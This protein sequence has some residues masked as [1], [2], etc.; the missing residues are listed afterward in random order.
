MNPPHRDVQQRPKK[1]IAEYLDGL[2]AQVLSQT[3]VRVIAHENFVSPRYAIWNPDRTR[4]LF[5]ADRDGLREWATSVKDVIMTST[6][7]V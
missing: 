6:D 5:Q 3:D 7:Q 2:D 4:L 1:V